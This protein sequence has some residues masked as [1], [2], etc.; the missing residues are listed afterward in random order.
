MA[1]WALIA[2]VLLYFLT[3]FDLARDKQY[4]LAFAFLCYALAN[5][6]LLWAARR[7]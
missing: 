2:T 3:A 4:G 1:S 7:T 6:G 5:I